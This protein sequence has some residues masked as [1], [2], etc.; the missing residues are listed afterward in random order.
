MK[1]KWDVLE[2]AQEIL[3]DAVDFANTSIDNA[4]A[5]L[6]SN[7]PRDQTL[8]KQLFILEVNRQKMVE[9]IRVFTNNQHALARDLRNAIGG[10]DEAKRSSVVKELGLLETVK[11][12]LRIALSRSQLNNTGI[13]ILDDCLYLVPQRP[14]A[15]D[16]LYTTGSKEADLNK[17]TERL[18]RLED[19][20]GPDE[21][22]AG[23]ATSILASQGPSH[24]EVIDKIA[25]KYSFT[26]NY[27]EKPTA[28]QLAKDVFTLTSA[29]SKDV[30]KSI[31][32]M[33]AITGPFFVNAAT[34][35]DCDKACAKVSFEQDPSILVSVQL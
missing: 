4:R 24:K 20:A 17:S 30:A 21:L 27:I 15:S 22:S 2:R 18:M 8:R 7:E 19:E 25:K 31:Q 14:G 16:L 9:A 6:P 10:H 5:P 1:K 23:G 11:Q 34:L 3:I 26:P 33:D 35:A 29:T 13:Q 32:R 12:E 28:E